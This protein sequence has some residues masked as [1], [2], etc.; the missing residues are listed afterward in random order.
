MIT[1]HTKSQT[2]DFTLV[3]HLFLD[4]RQR[5]SVLSLEDLEVLDEWQQAQY[6]VHFLM[7]FLVEFFETCQKNKKPFPFRLKVVD[8]YLVKFLS[9][10]KED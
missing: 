6:D 2:S 5:G 8:A 1:D 7:K 10:L 9:K 3:A 4:L